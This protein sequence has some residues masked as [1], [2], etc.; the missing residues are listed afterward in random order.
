MHKGK[1]I[2]VPMGKGIPETL[3]VSKIDETHFRASLVD[4][5]S[6]EGHVYHIN[7]AKN[8]EYFETVKAFLSHS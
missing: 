5:F 8:E 2:E 4:G 6:T 1:T 7:E 3:I